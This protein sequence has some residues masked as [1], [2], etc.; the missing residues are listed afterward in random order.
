MSSV[1]FALTLRDTAEDIPGPEGV[2]DAL[3]DRAPVPLLLD[4]PD[5][6]AL[7]V[8]RDPVSFGIPP[9]D[10][11][12]GGGIGGG[13]AVVVGGGP[14][15][16]KT[17]TSAYCALKLATD[18]TAVLFIAADEPSPRVAR[19][20]GAQAGESYSELT[21]EYPTVLSRLRGKLA[22]RGV[23]VR[24]THPHA[25]YAVEDVLEA[26]DREA[27]KDRQRIVIVDHLH[28]VMTRDAAD[29]DSEKVAIEKAVGTL[30][31]RY[32]R[33][34]GWS[35]IALSEVT[36]A[37]LT[38]AAVDAPMMAFAGTRK[39]ASRFDVALLLVTEDGQRVRVIPAKN[40]FGHKVPFTLEWDTERWVPVHVEDD[41]IEAA[42]STAKAARAAE[43]EAS[44]DSVVLAAVRK[45]IA[46]GSPLKKSDV[47]DSVRLRA[48][49]A[50]RALVRLVEN[51]VLKFE[52][53][54]AGTRGGARPTLVLEACR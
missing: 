47:P 29:G 5:A 6:L 24:I 9:L 35:V 42:R 13:E 15:T 46:S 45:A 8:P 17:T 3:T 27:P 11:C 39:I 34:K 22:A 31:D 48:R 28:S 21:S 14:G 19:K 1:A 20:I 12:L 4:L 38:V 52:L 33:S 37:A 36:K 40:R 23:F 49:D 10:D 26:F 16:Y 32:A 51:G 25:S 2:P 30:V 53:G 41:D 7:N 50:R 44:Q 54:L 18:R 43:I